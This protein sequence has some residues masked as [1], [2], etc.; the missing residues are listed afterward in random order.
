VATITRHDSPL[1]LLHAI[2][3][4]MMHPTRLTDRAAHRVVYKL[5]LR[6]SGLLLLLLLV[7]RLAMPRL[8][9][10][11]PRH[12]RFL[13]LPNGGKYAGSERQRELKDRQTHSILPFSG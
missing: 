2:S 11:T 10:G 7:V 3:A 13:R 9:G 12:E 4:M 8:I 1:H 6:R 5:A